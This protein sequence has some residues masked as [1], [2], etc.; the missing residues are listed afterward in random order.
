MSTS[1]A[2]KHK[3]FHTQFIL[4][5]QNRERSPNIKLLRNVIE[6]QSKTHTFELKRKQVLECASKTW[7]SNDYKT[8]IESINKLEASEVPQS[9]QLK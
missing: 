1:R 8:F 9:Y 5:L 3:V 2:S 6:Q 4:I 7:E